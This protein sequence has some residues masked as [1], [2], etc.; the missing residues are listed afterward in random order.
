MNGKFDQSK[1]GKKRVRVRSHSAFL[2]ID[3]IN[4]LEF[5]GGEKVL[6]WALKS[7]ARLAAFR[8]RAH[9]FSMPVIFVNDNFGLWR[10]SFSEVYAH[11]TRPEA[12]GKDLCRRL[13]PNRR[14]YFILKPR[15]SAFFATSLPPLLEDLEIERLILAG[16]A[17][18]LCVL[19]TAHDAHMH[20][21]P[22]TVLSDCCAAETDFDHNVALSQLARF[23]GATICLSSELQFQSEGTLNK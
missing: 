6:P 9:R 5:P 4:D 17:T 21:Y 23:C 20:Q 11:C 15:H 12:R 3:A 19:F 18:N 1:R 10:S 22:L 13:K 2:I 16:I 7:A 14:D 8:A